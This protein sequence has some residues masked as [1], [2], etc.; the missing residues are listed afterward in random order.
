MIASILGNMHIH[1][2]IDSKK[3]LEAKIDSHFEYNSQVDKANQP[4]KRTASCTAK[5]RVKATA[6][7][8]EAALA[9][10]RATKSKEKKE[11]RKAD[12]S[13]ANEAYKEI[14]EDLLPQRTKC[15]Y[16]RPVAYFM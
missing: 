7:D 12:S 4:A 2:F 14:L 15:K 13:A 5:R 10:R 6:I 8:E 1:V 3:D 16:A 9:I 11:K